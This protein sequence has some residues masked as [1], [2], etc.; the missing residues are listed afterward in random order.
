MSVKWR[1][2]L[3]L[4]M[5]LALDTA[6]QAISLALH[7]GH[8]VV[9]EQT[10]R[11]PNSHTVELAP[12]VQALLN[13]SGVS[14]PDLTAFAVCSG[15][16]SYSALRIGVSFAKALAGVAKKPLVGVMTFDI[17]AAGVVGYAPQ[18]AAQHGQLIATAQAGR[19]RV[20]VAKYRADGAAWALTDAPQVYEW[21]TLISELTASVWIAGEID[22]RGHELITLAQ[23]EN[24]NIIVLD[25]AARVR[26]AAC[27]AQIA[28]QR[29]ADEDAH[30][31]KASLLA[32]IY[33]KTKDTP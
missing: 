30:H 20:L 1:S 15:P 9:V 22:R 12:A 5:L 18:V 26:R 32:P 21:E 31:F 23:R 2:R 7:D 10:W 33:A 19:G 24:P 27:L 3:N 16:G 29:L 8:E 13:R 14:M 4:I 17:L 11:S 25:A 6:T 28:Q